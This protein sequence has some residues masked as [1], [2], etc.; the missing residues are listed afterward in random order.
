[1][2]AMEK[3]KCPV[4]LFTP[5]FQSP[6]RTS[7]SLSRS[8]VRLWAV[9]CGSQPW[10]SQA[11]HTLPALVCSRHQYATQFL[12]SITEAAF[13]KLVFWREGGPKSTQFSGKLKITEMDLHI[14]PLGASPELQAVS[15]VTQRAQ[16]AD[17][18]PQSVAACSWQFLSLVHF[19]GRSSRS[20]CFGL[21]SHSLG[22][23]ALSSGL[24]QQDY[25]LMIPLPAVSEYFQ[26]CFTPS[27]CAPSHAFSFESKIP[28]PLLCFRGIKKSSS[29][30]MIF[31][32]YNAQKDSHS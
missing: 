15:H 7:A 5:L 32:M 22:K 25:F 8:L 29:L 9:Q 13:S 21:N 24:A 12:G 6:A 20:V 30:Y 14:L 1:M 31:S 10:I 17:P 26:E 23:T 27:C 2:E 18:E 11:S 4:L 28:P 19:Q 3:L 16:A